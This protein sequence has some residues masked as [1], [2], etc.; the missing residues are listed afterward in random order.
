MV[1]QRALRL[2]G[3]VSPAQAASLAWLAALHT[4]EDVIRRGLTLVEIVVQD[5]YTHDVVT[6]TGE[7][8]A[9]FD[10]T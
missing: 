3:D 5:E 10:S 9:V 8:Y 7:L 2:C 1:E 6:Q 4:L